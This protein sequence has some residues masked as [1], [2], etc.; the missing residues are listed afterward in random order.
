M[1][2]SSPKNINA[3]ILTGEWQDVRGK[4]L[5][6]FVGTSD[7]LGIV[8]MTFS[9]N[10][11]FFI[12]NKSIITSLS[13]PF[14]RKEVDLKNL[15]EKKVDAL[16][17]NSQRDLRTAEEELGR[18]GVKTFESDI[19]P[20]RRFLMERFIN[21]Q[22]QVDGSFNEKKNLASFSNPKIL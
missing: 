20:A 11:V 13:V 4:N 10:P 17:F 22:V 15:E 2:E 8:E 1:P 19:D 9:N 16:Y 14:N 18:M 7:G 21:A 12:E 5:L 6:R 3:F